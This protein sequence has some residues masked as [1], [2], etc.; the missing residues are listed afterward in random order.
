MSAASILIARKVL[1]FD[2]FNADEARFEPRTK[3]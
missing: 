1:N 3:D 2:S